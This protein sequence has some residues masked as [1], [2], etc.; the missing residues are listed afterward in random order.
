M[1][2]GQTKEMVVIPRREQIKKNG[3]ED[4][5]GS[6]KEK[7]DRNI[8]VKQKDD[9]CRGG[10]TEKRGNRKEKNRKDDSLEAAEKILLTINL[11]TTI[12]EST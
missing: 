2:L 3:K 7:D 11:I 10:N 12:A 9:K 8:S 6:V 5:K 1:F 4:I